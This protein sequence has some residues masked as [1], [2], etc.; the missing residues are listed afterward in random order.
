M[1]RFTD[2]LYAT[3]PSLCIALPLA[4]WILD[5]T[6]LQGVE[7]LGIVGI[8]AAGILFFVMERRSFIAKSA[9]RLA[10]VEKRIGELENKVTSGNDQVVHLLGEQ[11]IALREIK[12]G[13]VENFNRM[14]NI[15]LRAIN[16][17]IPH[18]TVSMQPPSDAKHVLRPEEG[19]GQS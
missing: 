16:G 19:Q 15:T 8:L 4:Q 18:D 11:L 6:F 14:W 5:L 9:E 2:Y 1:T 17:K 12:D 10:T 13:Q 3:V 7:K